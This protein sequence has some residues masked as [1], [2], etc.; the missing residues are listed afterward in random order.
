MGNPKETL[1]KINP[2]GNTLLA[3]SLFLSSC[4]PFI[5][6]P[7]TE[8]NNYSSDTLI[9]E[10]TTIDLSHIPQSSKGEM[11]KEL[12]KLQE[13]LR[14]YVNTSEQELGKDLADNYKRAIDSVNSS[15][16][17]TFRKSI[18]TLPFGHP[19]K[20][21]SS[22]HFELL[23][24]SFDFSRVIDGKTRK[25]INDRLWLYLNRE[26]KLQNGPSSK[27][28]M[29]LNQIK[30]RLEIFKI[31]SGWITKQENTIFNQHIGY[32]VHSIL[33]RYPDGSSFGIYGTTKGEFSIQVHAGTTNDYLAP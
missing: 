32:N 5:P 30:E 2:I 12:A 8:R 23:N 11:Q 28:V 15:R 3:S 4:V 17:E 10:E 25:P 13:I 31:P 29:N 14:F 26:G 7:P 6:P 18:D 33:Y 19:L 20:Q 24:P 9:G 1:R 21:N 22:I 16:T 27:E